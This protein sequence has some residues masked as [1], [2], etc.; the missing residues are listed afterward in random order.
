MAMT[1]TTTIA[2][3]DKTGTTQ[4]AD[5][6]ENSTETPRLTVQHQDRSVGIYRHWDR[7]LQR[8]MVPSVCEHVHEMYRLVRVRSATRVH[9]IGVHV[10]V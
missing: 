5:A 4:F 10:C 3:C 1:T 7:M 6:D 8:M 9:G 2:C